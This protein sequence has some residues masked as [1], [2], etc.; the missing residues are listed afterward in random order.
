MSKK[1]IA[2][3]S[4][5]IA[6][7]E[8]SNPKIVKFY[9]IAT[10]KPQNFMV[11]HSLPIIEI[12]LNQVEQSLERK[13]AFL[14]VNRDLYLTTVHKTEKNNKIT[15]ICDSFQWHDKHDVLA[16]IAD[17]KLT[18]FFYPTVSFIDNSLFTL[19]NSVK[20]VPELG[21]LPQIS[22]YCET[23]VT[24]RRRDGGVITVANS[25]YPTILL[26]FCEKGKWEKATKLCRF[27]K[28]HLLWS[29]LAAASLKHKKLESAETAFAAIEAPEKVIFISEL[30]DNPSEIVRNA[31]LALLYH[32]VN[33]AEQIY[34]QNK[35]YYQAIRMHIDGYRW[36]RALKLARDYK[37]HIDIVV[38]FRKKYLDRIGK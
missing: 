34:T 21:R 20:E 13:I 19:T 18:T 17:S 10:G 29:I 14:D 12:D 33:E 5:V 31:S 1:K 35:H 25:P 28:E 8:T 38:A 24:I 9:E 27:V 37:V 2:I 32:K 36:E 3:S 23:Q 6:V 15:T 22:S 7:V 16:S 4:D 30:R 26:D 11:E